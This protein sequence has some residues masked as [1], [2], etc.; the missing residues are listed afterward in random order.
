MIPN[1]AIGALL[2][3][4]VGV[5]LEALARYA[6]SLWI[7]NQYYC[8]RGQQC[9]IPGLY[10]VVGASAVLAGATRT[11]VALV[12][13]MF[14]LLGRLETIIPI[15]IGVMFAK[16]VADATQKQGKI[17]YFLAFCKTQTKTRIDS[18]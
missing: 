9:V 4:L 5:G 2:G 15:M 7:W 6:P 13:I 8:T 14:E 11:T 18:N 16:W 1:L 10:A 17:D 3:R 12:V